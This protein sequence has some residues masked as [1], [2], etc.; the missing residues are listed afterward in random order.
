MEGKR[1]V[2]GK[3]CRNKGKQEGKQEERKGEVRETGRNSVI[4]REI[5]LYMG[6]EKG[7]ISFAQ[8]SWGGFSEEVVID[9]DPKGS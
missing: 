1:K 2:G 7:T 5:V 4:R 3:G 9:L 8:E 6:K